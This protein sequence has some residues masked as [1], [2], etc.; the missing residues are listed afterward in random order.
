MMNKIAVQ[1]GG[2]EKLYS[3]KEA[4]KR[5]RDWGFDAV[6]ANI[7]HVLPCNDI[8]KGTIPETLIRGG[9]DC[10]CSGHRAGCHSGGSR[11]YR[12]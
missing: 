5:I 6:D 10:S 7:D 8:G 4:Y 11:R 12:N 1:T 9:R 3:V 2:T